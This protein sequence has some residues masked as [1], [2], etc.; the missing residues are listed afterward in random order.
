MHCLLCAVI[1]LNIEYMKYNLKATPLT[2]Q[3]G[4]FTLL[5]FYF[6]IPDSCLDLSHLNLSMTSR[7][8]TTLPVV[9]F[10]Q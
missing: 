3:M 7:L 9:E 8:N 10:W 4:I 2:L 1:V 5:M 6:P